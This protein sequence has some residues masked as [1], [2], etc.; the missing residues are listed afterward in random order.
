MAFSGAVNL[1]VDTSGR[2][3]SEEPTEELLC[4]AYTFVYKDKLTPA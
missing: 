2:P 3:C 1:P 4:L